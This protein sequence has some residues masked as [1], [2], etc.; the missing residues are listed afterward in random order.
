MIRKTC[1]HCKCSYGHFPYCPLVL[2]IK[3]EKPQLPLTPAQRTE[4]WIKEVCAKH[5]V[6]FARF[7]RPGTT[8][9]KIEVAAVEEICEGLQARGWGCVRI[10]QRLGRDHTTISDKLKKLK[11]KSLTICHEEE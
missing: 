1:Q 10:A 7:S 3:A 5:G 11:R 6:D 2:A 8:L 4:I 9:Y